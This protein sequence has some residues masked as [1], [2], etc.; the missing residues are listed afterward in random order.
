MKMLARCHGRSLHF[1]FPERIH[2]ITAGSLPDNGIY[3][4]YKGI[5]RRHFRILKSSSGWII[6][7]LGSTNGTSLNGKP[8]Q[9]SP[10]VSGDLIQAGIVEICLES[11]EGENDIIPI[12]VY[13]QQNGDTSRTDRITAVAAE[14][15]NIFSFP[16]FVFPDGVISGVSSGMM[17]VYR[18]LH[19]ILDSN[20]SVLLIGETGS[21]KEI[22]VRMFHLSSNRS[23]GPFIA[24][25]CAAMP[26]DLVEAELFGIGDKVATNVNQRKGKMAAAT[27]G[28]LFLDEIS[29]F[30][31]DL[32]AKI[33]RALEERAV[34]PVGENRLIPTDFRL[35]SAT[36]QDPEDLIR[37]KKL[38]EDLYHRI[39]EVELYI[40]PLRERKED[41]K[42][43]IPGLLSRFSQKENKI[44]AGISRPLWNLLLNYSYPGNV[45]EL[46]NLLKAIV[47]LAHPGEIL[48]LHLVPERLLSGGVDTLTLSENQEV[49]DLRERVS[50]FTRKIIEGALNEHQGSVRDAARDLKV[51]PFGLRKMMKRHHIG[52]NGN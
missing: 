6:K 11:A 5:S 10:V 49:H 23:E 20:V 39:A 8:I 51:T 44:F 38:R 28:I 50:A 3:L 7:D 2:E 31:F 12:P 27:G 1:S 4:P 22:L 19:S 40:P 21:G 13:P 26:C 9:E 14:E 36:N 46:S 17:K 43:L 16:R 42:V 48:D 18:K 33:L 41:L 35:I 52:K 34:C 37:A 32:Q 30:P 24:V 25:N 45:R 47:A 15:E 29:A